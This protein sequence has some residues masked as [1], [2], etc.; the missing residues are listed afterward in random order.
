MI[1]FSVIKKYFRVKRI[2]LSFLFVFCLQ[3]CKK[4]YD[5]TITD[6]EFFPSELY[7]PRS[8]ENRFL[9]YELTFVSDF[10][11]TQPGLT[12]IYDIQYTTEPGPEGTYP[13]LL[14]DQTISSSGIVT[15]VGYGGYDNDFFIS[16]PEGNPWEGVYIYFA[17]ASPSIGD[18][19][20]ITGDV[21]E[22]YGFTELR[23]A[24]VNVISSGQ[25][26]A[27]TDTC[28]HWRL[29]RTCQCRSVRMLPCE[30]R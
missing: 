6:V 5:L 21:Y 10:T 11:V 30:S 2:I 28:K 13:S 25:S 15:A 19:V 24:S 20:E 17:D 22:Y 14:A 4:D 8:V 3:S 18:M 27:G 1:F 9:T 12:S 26:C 29:D 7:N 16:S 23:Y